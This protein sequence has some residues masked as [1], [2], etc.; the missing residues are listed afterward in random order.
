M[1]QVIFPSFSGEPI[2][3]VYFLSSIEVGNT[4]WCCSGSGQTNSQDDPPARRRFDHSMKRI[5]GFPK[6]PRSPEAELYSRRNAA[7]AAMVQVGGWQKVTIFTKKEGQV[8][9]RWYSLS[10]SG[11]WATSTPK[12]S[13]SHQHSKTGS[14]V[15]FAKDSA[16]LWT[17]GAQAFRWRILPLGYCTLQ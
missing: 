17:R 4:S 2:R 7:P 6:R 5:L 14:I 1:L 13:W 15:A 11:F 10:T 3:L 8:G 16:E 9:P 12:E